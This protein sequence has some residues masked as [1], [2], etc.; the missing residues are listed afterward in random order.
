M[1]NIYGDGQE[2]LTDSHDSINLIIQKS[3]KDVRFLVGKNYEKTWDNK[4][5]EEQGFNS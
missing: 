1:F 2:I 5:L 3:N 4:A